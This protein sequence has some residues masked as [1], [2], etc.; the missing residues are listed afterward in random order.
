MPDYEILGALT[1]WRLAIESKLKC[2]QPYPNDESIEDL[3]KSYGF[4]ITSP[5]TLNYVSEWFD[6]DKITTYLKDKHASTH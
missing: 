2:I 3:A 5:H 4:H 6:W 1:A